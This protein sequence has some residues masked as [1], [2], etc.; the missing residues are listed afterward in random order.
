LQANSFGAT[1]LLQWPLAGGFAVLK[2][3]PYPQWQT[4]HSSFSAGRFLA[5]KRGL[6]QIR[7]LTIDSLGNPRSCIHRAEMR[8]NYARLAA[9]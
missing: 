8:N 6:P 1:Y 3:L 2:Q 5:E 7:T 9:A 4:L